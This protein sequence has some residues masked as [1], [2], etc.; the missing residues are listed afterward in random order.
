MK[1][2][3]C[4]IKGWATE[5]ETVVALKDGEL[6]GMCSEDAINYLESGFVTL[7]ELL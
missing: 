4:G 6:I 7:K 5:A 3:V 2:G 1:C